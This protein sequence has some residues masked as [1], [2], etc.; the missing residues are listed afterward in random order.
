MDKVAEFSASALWD[1]VLR[2]SLTAAYSRAGA[3]AAQ[4]FFDA[5]VSDMATRRR[6]RFVLD[7]HEVRGLTLH[8]S[9]DVTV[10]TPVDV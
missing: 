3:T 1:Q 8:Q 5:S 10:L 6:V 4:E 7:E 2:R 9:P